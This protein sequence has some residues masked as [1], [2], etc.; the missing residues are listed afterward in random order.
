MLTAG[1]PDEAREVLQ[2]R[3][4]HLALIDL[5]LTDESRSD[6]SGLTLVKETDPDIPKIIV[7][8]YVSQQ[9]THESLR[10]QQDGTHPAVDF[11]GKQQGWEV[12][13]KAVNDSFSHHV[14]VDMNLATG[15]RSTASRSCTA[16]SR[17]WP[18]R[19]SSTARWR[20]KTSSDASS[21]GRKNC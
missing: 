11:I 5:R 14:R 9:A 4:V 1:N 16:S 2:N 18:K 21:T 12:M 19:T 17:A 8:A 6:I 10:M 15:A 13:V 3:W 7:T 20:S